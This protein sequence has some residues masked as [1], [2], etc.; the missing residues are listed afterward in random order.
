MKKNTLAWF[1]IAGAGIAFSGLG[2]AACSSSSTGNPSTG[3]TDSGSNA[4]GT[5]KSDGSTGSDGGTDDSGTGGDCGRAP[6]LHVTD[7]GDIFCGYLD[8]GGSFDCLT[9]NECCLG[10]SIGS[11]N[12]DPE[13]CAAWGTACTNPADG[14]VPIECTQ[15]ADC[16]AN[17][18]PGA[19]CLQG[20]TAPAVVAGCG[21]SKSTR[22]NA[23]VCEESDAAAPACSGAG[24][25]QVCSADTDC[26][27]GK[28]CVASKWKL[29]NLGFC[30]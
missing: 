26:P 3:D 6:T 16:T 25:L 22:G 10:G 21:Y 15:S 5:T 19:C 8:D 1:V 27:S 30:Q 7:P 12:F 29:Y 17:G 18:K 13:Q 11:G 20:A 28:T 24:E 9:G 4:D 14:G 2:M 23:I